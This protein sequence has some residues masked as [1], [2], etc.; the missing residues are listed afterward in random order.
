MATMEEKLTIKSTFERFGVLATEVENDDIHF[1]DEMCLPY[2][3]M[4]EPSYESKMLEIYGGKFALS[5]FMKT[6][7]PSFGK[8]KMKEVF[9]YS[10]QKI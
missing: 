5:K 2:E 10:F 4:D 6:I 9:Q 1:L 7:F 3:I 8:E